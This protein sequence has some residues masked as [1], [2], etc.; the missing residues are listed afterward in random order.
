MLNRKEEHRMSTSRRFAYERKQSLGKISSSGM[1]DIHTPSFLDSEAYAEKK[2][3]KGA[4]EFT[5]KK[6]IVFIMADITRASRIFRSFSLFCNV[7]SA[8]M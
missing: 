7:T 2:T 8:Q 4:S 1:C 3:K 6:F 5:K